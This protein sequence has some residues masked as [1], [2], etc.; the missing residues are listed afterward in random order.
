ME[1]TTLENAEERKMS[2]STEPFSSHS[3]LSSCSISTVSF[4]TQ[5]CISLS[6]FPL[7][8]APKVCRQMNARF[9]RHSGPSEFTMP[10][11]A[12]I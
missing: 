5:F 11:N 10:A 8:F 3:L 6:G 1:Q 7:F 4:C 12:K 2:G 9:S